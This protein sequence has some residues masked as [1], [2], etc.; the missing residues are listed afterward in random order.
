MLKIRTCSVYLVTNNIN[1]KVYVGQT[2]R[3]LKNRFSQHCSDTS[4]KLGDDIRRIGKSHFQ[5]HLLDDSATTVE[6]L[7][8]KEEYYMSKYN[9]IK[10]GYN[11]KAACK[12]KMLDL[13]SNERVPFTFAIEEQNILPLKIIA[14]K[15]G[16]SVADI[17]NELLLEYL[18]KADE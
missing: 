8:E 5:I 11:K 3:S 7:A 13:S 17:L 2:V 10:N 9:S 1:E 15:Q 12:S 6:E 4:S 14:I 16:R 18:L